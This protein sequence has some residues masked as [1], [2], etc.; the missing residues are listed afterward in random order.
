MDDLPFMELG[1]N[2]RQIQG[3]A[4]SS[5]HSD[6]QMPCAAQDEQRL[7]VGFEFLHTSVSKTEEASKFITDRGSSSMIDTVETHTTY[8][9]GFDD[10]D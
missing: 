5:R 10:G 6:V 9:D 2:F 7:R 4:R 1:L 8:V 3:D